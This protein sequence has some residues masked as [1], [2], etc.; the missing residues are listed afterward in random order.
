MKAISKSYQNYK[1]HRNN[2][3][4]LGKLFNKLGLFDGNSITNTCICCGLT[5]TINMFVENKNYCKSCAV[6]KT[7]SFLNSP[8]QHNEDYLLHKY[9]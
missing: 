2:G 7:I 1:K 3:N 4:K 9:G 6:S 5:K 8:M